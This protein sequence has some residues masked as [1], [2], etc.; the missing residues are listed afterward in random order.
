MFTRKKPKE[1]IDFIFPYVDC[2]DPEWR[3]LYNSE[4][5][6]RNDDDKLSKSLAT[7]DERFRSNGL[8]KY[9]FRSIDKYLPWINKVHM[10]VQSDSQVPEWINRDKVSIVYHEDFI[11]KEYLP[12]FNSC[13]IEM[14]LYRIEE[15][16]DK[17]IYGNDDVFINYNFKKSDFFINDKLVYGVKAR[18]I[19]TNWIWD[20]TLRLNNQKLLNMPTTIIYDVQHTILPHTK[21][22]IERVHNIYRNKIK[23]SISPFRLAKNYSQWLFSLYY[24]KYGKTQNRP[25]AY[26]KGH[27]SEKCY[28]KLLNKW[29]SYK[30]ICL[31]DSVKTTYETTKKFIN[32]FEQHFP[33]KSKYEL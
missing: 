29:R 11:P 18:R 6:K 28:N 31:N 25:H 5:D 13:T 2:N 30:S 19:H 23:N 26:I 15:L 7:G 4:I 17:F 33:E 1:E 10:I 32:L 20:M 24:Y 27:I 22:L 12:T 14:F 16:S 9:V 21:T 8:L 3:A